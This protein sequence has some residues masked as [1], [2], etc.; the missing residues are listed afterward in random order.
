MGFYAVIPSIAC[1]ASALPLKMD[2]TIAPRRQQ[3]TYVQTLDNALAPALMV[4]ADD[5]VFAHCVESVH[6]AP[7]AF[8]V[9]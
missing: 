3:V 9:Q 1:Q 8:G 5:Q 4:C 6:A 7:R 2:P